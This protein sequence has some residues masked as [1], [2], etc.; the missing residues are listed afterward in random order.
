MLDSKNRLARF[1]T[2]SEG[3]ALGS[4]LQ[5]DF[6]QRAFSS[7]GSGTADGKFR[8]RAGV[9][10]DAGAQSPAEVGWACWGR[11]QRHAANFRTMWA[12]IEVADAGLSVPAGDLAGALLPQLLLQRNAELDA[13]ARAGAEPACCTRRTLS[14]DRGGNE[15]DRCRD[16]QSAR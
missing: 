10:H 11:W 16:R 14:R 3:T 2:R 6:E 5:P 7:A 12:V 1:L 15:G 9:D 8:F 13:N 4:I